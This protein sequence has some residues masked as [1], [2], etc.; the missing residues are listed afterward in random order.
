VPNYPSSLPAVDH[1]APVPRRIRAY[2]G[3]ELI[4][5]TM[6]ARYVWEWPHYPQFY[7]PAADVRTGFVSA[8]RGSES[9]SRGAVTVHDLTVGDHVRPGAVRRLRESSVGGL[10]D[11]VRLEFAALDSWFEENEQ[12]FVHPRDPY[13]RVDALRGSQPVRVEFHGLVL[14]DS[15]APVLV[16]ETGLPTRYYLDR[17][18]V[19]FTHLVATDTETQCPYKGRTSGY[20][21]VD[22][23]GR[24]H[25]D[26]A[27]TYDF[28]TRQVQPIAGLIAFYNEKVDLFVGG[29]EIPRPATHF[30]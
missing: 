5:D 9:T 13:T 11:T 8:E 15:A 7:L 21:S 6:G 26:L 17:T 19:D 30:S 20:W 16:F 4:V 22:V 25:P 24:L 2:L 3:G 14:A 10:S 29:V 28:P 27:W 18:D 23:G 1:V 12:I